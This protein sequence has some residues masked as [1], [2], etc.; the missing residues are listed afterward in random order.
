MEKGKS[1]K[2][3]MCIVREYRS[4]CKALGWNNVSGELRTEF[5]STTARARGELASSEDAEKS[6][7]R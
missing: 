2:E 3:T 5:N 6:F 7:P 1:L 4:H